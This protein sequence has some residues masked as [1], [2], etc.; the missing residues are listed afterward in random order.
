[1]TAELPARSQPRITISSSGWPSA[2]LWNST[3]S[4]LAP[5]SPRGSAPIKFLIYAVDED[6][7]FH[8]SCHATVMRAREDPSPS[9]LT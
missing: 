7:P 1:M 8:D 9:F 6:S 2:A 5:G 3:R 4:I